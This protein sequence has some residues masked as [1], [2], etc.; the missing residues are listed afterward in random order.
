MK[1]IK[2]IISC[3]IC[4][5][6]IAAA[7]TQSFAL[8][9]RVIKTNTY[10]A[11]NAKTAGKAK[12][13]RQY[14]S[15]PANHN[16]ASLLWNIQSSVAQKKK[17]SIQYANGSKKK[18]PLNILIN[19]KKISKS[20]ASTKKYAKWS[21]YK[22]SLNFKKGKNA[23]KIQRKNKK[24]PAIYIKRIKIT[25]TIV[26]GGS[27]IQTPAPPTTTPVP[28]NSAVPEQTGENAMPYAAWNVFKNETPPPI[29][30]SVQEKNAYYC[31]AD[32]NDNAAGTIDD[33]WLSPVLAAKKLKAGD[34]LYLRGGCYF[35]DTPI[36][37]NQSGN[38]DALITLSAYG[39]EA[40]TI[41]GSAYDMT[42]DGFWSGN[43]IVT[44]NNCGFIRI[45][46]ISVRNSHGM[47]IS[48]IGSHDIEILNCKSHNTYAPGIGVWNYNYS[49]PYQLKNFKIIGNEIT[50]ANTWDM[51][52]AG[53][54][55][56]GE[57]PHEAI[58]IAGAADFEVAFNHVHDCDK[59]GIDVKE[60][61]RNG[62][63]HHN[64]VHDVDRQGLY[65]DSWFGTLS[66]ITFYNNVVSN[67][68][69]AGL[70]V[71]NEGDSSV[72]PA[73]LKNITFKN[74]LVYHCWG[75]GFFSSV[76]G[77]DGPRENISVTNNTFYHNGY[78]DGSGSH[79]FIM[80][81]CQLFSSNV[82]NLKIEKNI[83]AE[84]KGFEIGYSQNWLPVADTFNERSVAVNNNAVYDV[85]SNITYP[86]RI[87][88]GGAWAEMRPYRGTNDINGDPLFVNAGKFN[89]DLQINSPAAG[90]G[91]LPL[92]RQPR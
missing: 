37:F 14:V 91:C 72:R 77:S 83:F 73:V 53:V 28:T 60:V 68:K 12:K 78:G 84:N 82:K 70:A 9:S 49:N 65:C 15:L 87:G 81:G 86:L 54:A 64:Y 57:P 3:M 89:F 41:D 2:K 40:V 33:P 62:T 48:V 29:D 25:T 32:G 75:P 34:A 26:K 85:N 27:C 20:F 55:K 52:P 10:K 44:V 16:K 59:E 30:Y 42:T 66:D 6:Y 43:G 92:I 8:P 22:I 31:S 23:L 88:Y 56:E 90:Y 47:G 45:K 50:K 79:F 1:M 17:V 19:G 63:V 74:N 39:Y 7:T 51:I 18:I 80:G 71:S 38:A 11:V 67:C 61:S 46:N 76:W 21:E 24:S 36:I 58:S 69:S 35:I 5:V 13:Y 4:L